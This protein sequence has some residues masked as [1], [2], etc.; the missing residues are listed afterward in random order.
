MTQRPIR[1]SYRPL[2]IL[3]FPIIHLFRLVHI[4]GGGFLHIPQFWQVWSLIPL[5]PFTHPILI[6]WFGF[7]YFCHTQFFTPLSTSAPLL[8]V[9][10]ISLIHLA[11][12]SIFSLCILLLELTLPSLVVFTKLSPFKKRVTF[13]QVFSP[14][15]SLFP[16]LDVESLPPAFYL[17]T[18]FLCLHCTFFDPSSGPPLNSWSI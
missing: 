10:L 5:P 15:V 14:F 13:W 16:P 17:F 7:L 3:N 18:L 1:P 4:F 8:S 9:M 6:V 2:A 11:F 12:S